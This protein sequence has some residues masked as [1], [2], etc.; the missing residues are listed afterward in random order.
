MSER[1]RK[2]VREFSKDFMRVMFEAFD[3]QGTDGEEEILEKACQAFEDAVDE[4]MGERESEKEM[5]EK[6]S[7]G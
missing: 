4:I 3:A 2:R 5:T 1:G 7:W 6:L